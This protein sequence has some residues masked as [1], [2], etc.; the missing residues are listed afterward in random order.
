M[1]ETIKDFFEDV[2]GK[3]YIKKFKEL[4]KAEDGNVLVCSDNQAYS[5]DDIVKN[6]TF[7]KG[8]RSVDAIIPY[9]S[10]IVL[11]EFKTG[12]EDK[13]DKTTF[14]ID[15]LKEMVFCEENEKTCGKLSDFTSEYFKQF[16]DLRKAQKNELISILKIKLYD[17]LF[18]INNVVLPQCVQDRNTISIEYVIVVDSE[19]TENKENTIKEIKN[20]KITTASENILIESKIRAILKTQD[21]NNIPICNDIKV[22]NNEHFNELIKNYNVNI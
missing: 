20:F 9:E 19:Y 14:S 16:G 10:K 15:K 11:I 2:Y 7:N 13:I 5:F 4:S 12:F 6:S 21:K 3:N 1:Y 22:V 18:F 8:L 17:S